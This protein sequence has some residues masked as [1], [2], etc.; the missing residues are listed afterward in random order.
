MPSN[1]YQR[2]IKAILERADNADITEGRVAYFR[3]RE[4][5]LLL[6]DHYGYSLEEAIAVFAALSP[7]NDYSG[8]LRS[9]ATVLK[10]YK[11]GVDV[12]LLRVTTYNACRDRAYSYLSGVSF[13]DTVDGPKIRNFYANILNPLD[14]YPVTI[15]GHAVN[16]WRN[17]LSTV[18]GVAER[19]F[20]YNRVANDY[21]EV[22]GRI[23]LL[24][25][26]VQ[27]IVWFAWKRIHNI[28][29]AGYKHRQLEL[30]RDVTLDLW[31]TL[32]SPEDIPPFPYLE[33]PSYTTLRPRIGG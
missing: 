24:P 25:H 13:L 6:A 1:R 33:T 8:N 9:A 11:E 26:Q 32:R 7:N 15:D 4:V 28:R 17:K 31:R 29:F 19:G 16:V 18:K 21:R 12:N 10:G 30:Y 5:C 27:A 20:N 23:K 2:N 14:P 22:A 3:Y